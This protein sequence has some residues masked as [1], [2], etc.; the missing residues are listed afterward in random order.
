MAN[1]SVKLLAGLTLAGVLGGCASMSSMFGS[2]ASTVSFTNV[3]DSAVN[4]RFFVEDFGEDGTGSGQFTSVE[5][6][7]VNRGDSADYKLSRSASFQANGEAVVH[8]QVSPV[9]PSWETKSRDYWLELLTQPPVSIVATGSVSDLTFNTG[10]GEIA[11][12]PSKEIKGFE[13]RVA[14]A[15]AAA[16]QQQP[17]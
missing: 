12:I 2:S 11:V 5:S 14:D 4:V 1:Q 7:Q 17:E 16:E 10:Q 15:Q 3:S 8:V 9:T 6:F 13:H